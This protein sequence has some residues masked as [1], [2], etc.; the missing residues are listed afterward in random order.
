MALKTRYYEYTTFF[1]PGGY[2]TYLLIFRRMVSTFSNHR[3]TD[4]H[5]YL[6]L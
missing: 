2:I 4:I 6:R 1:L 3:P 5:E